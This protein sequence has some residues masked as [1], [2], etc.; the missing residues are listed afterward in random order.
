MTGNYSK[1]WVQKNLNAGA[2]NRAQ[3]AIQSLGM[4]LPC[5]V[6][7]VDGAIVTVAFDVQGIALPQVTIPKLESAWLRNPTQVGDLGITIAA[8][9]YLGGVSGL[10]GGTASNLPT[11]SLEGL[12]FVPVSNSNSA[13][14]DPNAAQVSGPNGAILKATGGATESEVVT[15]QNGT[16]LTFGANSI[17]ITSSGVT[18][19]VGGATFTITSSG[20]T[21]SVAMTAPDLTVPNGALNSHIHFV[22]AAP[23][24]SNTLTG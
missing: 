2:I 1:L 16:T 3:E 14:I 8:D 15:N 12:V 4:A 18:I 19:T 17:A 22:P 23:G 21:S 6:V 13:P 7:A 10:G 24:N 20:V 11:F 5:H 9:T